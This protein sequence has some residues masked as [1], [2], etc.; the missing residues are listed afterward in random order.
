MT[1]VVS[2]VGVGVVL[3]SREEE[4]FEAVTCDPTSEMNIGFLLSD[5]WWSI[6]MILWLFFVKFLIK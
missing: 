3:K 6:E 2:G 4:N 1:V 5:F